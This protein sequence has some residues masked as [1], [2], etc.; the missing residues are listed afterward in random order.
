[1]KKLVHDTYYKALFGDSKNELFVPTSFNTIK[2]KKHVLRSV[3]VD[4]I[5]LSC[6]DN[7]RFVLDDNINTYALG[8]YKTAE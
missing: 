3:K 2:S 8:H 6:V 5:G 7:K 1:M 4:K